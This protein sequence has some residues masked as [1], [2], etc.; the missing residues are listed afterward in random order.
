MDQDPL[1]HY[2]QQFRQTAFQLDEELANIR[3]SIKK[4]LPL[5]ASTYEQVDCCLT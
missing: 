4:Q 1:L 3:F 2:Q 5:L